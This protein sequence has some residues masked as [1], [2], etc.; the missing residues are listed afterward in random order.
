MDIYGYFDDKNREYVITRPDTPLP[1]INYLGCEKYFGIISNTAGGYS[2]Y[3]DAGLRR[4]TR[5]R[6]NNV[7][8]D[9]GGRYLYIKDGDTI[10]NPGWKPT[11]TLLD[12]YSCRHGMGY[13]IIK[14]IK[15][16]V[17]VE[18]TYFVPLGEDM[19]I[20]KVEFV[21]HTPHRK[22]LTLFSFVEF[23]LWEAMDDMTNFQR[24]FNTGEVEVEGETIFHKTEYRE[25]RNHYAYFTCNQGI[26]GYDTSRDDFIGVHNG[27]EEPE[28][29]I[30]GKC[31][32]SIAHGWAPIGAHQ[33]NITL[34][35]GQNKRLH[36]ILGYME[37]EEDK[38]FS[39][40]G[41]INKKTFKAKMSVYKDAQVVDK[42]FEELK[43]YW[44]ELLSRYRVEIENEDVKRMVN[45]WNQYQCMVTFNMSRSA[46]LYESGIGRGIGFR[47]TNQ[48]LLGF[49]H[50]VPERARQRILDIAGIQFSDGSCYHQYQPLTK[51]GNEDIGGGFNDDPLWLIVSTCAYIKETG[52]FSILDEAIGYSDKPGS[53]ATILDHLYLSVN[54]TLR[55]LGPHNLPLIGRADWNDCLNLNCFSKEPGESFQLAGVVS[56]SIAESVMIAGLF[57]YACRE[58]MALLHQIEAKGKID[59]IKQG[60]KLIKE[61]VE[62]HGWDGE[63]FL[64]AY[65]N[66]GTKVGSKECEEGKIFIEPQ[67]WCI[68]GGVGLKDGKA[69]KALD[70]VEKY[71][72]TPY[73]IVLQQPAYSRYY[74]NLGE[75]SSY[76]PGYKENS[77]IFCHT[78]PWIS[79]AETIL[80]DGDKAFDY[81]LRI[82]PNTKEDLIEVY[83]CE[84]YCYAQ[85]IAGKDAA[86]HGEAKNSWLTGTASWSFVTISQ[87]ILGI[88][89]DYQ[90]LLID[91]CIPKNWKSYKVTRLYRGVKYHI[92]VQNHDGVSKGI[93]SLI[94]NGK[95]IE[96]NLIPYKKEDKEVEVSVV[97]DN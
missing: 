33:L 83:R 5:Y 85:M 70:S 67:A 50:M 51:E 9:I 20:W 25:R 31:T 79:I 26:D 53:K 54:F 91:P 36:F 47:D 35:P 58:L 76:P 60:Y 72:A 41:V 28:A 22:V 43:I 86:T 42:A 90:G 46:S 81:Y 69:Q 18:V 75:I 94:V 95:P 92:R 12:G 65:D 66:Y 71:L 56:D 11:K 61:A 37:N 89:P 29:V 16:T 32:N 88:K 74:L 15:N 7:P 84:P 3:K 97:L 34:E 49:V 6:Y 73:G 13:T 4:I 82:C 23:C 78:N 14:G 68:I 48:D 8:I 44:A 17:E 2:F 30:K 40:P 10:W 38:K 62:E 59:E 96:G 64:R 87:A 24:N 80:G 55:N 39:A 27:L 77:G 21:N 63:W 57:L 52:D 45:I 1:W 19:E 93:K